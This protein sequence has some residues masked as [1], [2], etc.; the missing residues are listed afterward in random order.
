MTKETIVSEW[1]KGHSR[2]WLE[3]KQ[4]ADIEFLDRCKGL[5]KP[6][7]KKLAK[8]D[9]EEALLEWWRKYVK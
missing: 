4:Y 9:I 5:K 2:Q 1:R 8:H 6:E 7:I 3:D